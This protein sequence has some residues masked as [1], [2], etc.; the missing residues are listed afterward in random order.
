M[1]QKKT[2][3]AMA[4]ALRA[5]ADIFSY[6]TDQ[7]GA[8][9]RVEL[10]VP[11]VL[12]DKEKLTVTFDECSRLTVT[13]DA[14]MKAGLAVRIPAWARSSYPEAADGYMRFGPLKAGE[15]ASVNLPMELREIREASDEHYYSLAYGPYLLA[16]VSDSKELLSPEITEIKADGASF[17]DGNLTLMPLYRIDREHYHVYYYK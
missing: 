6:G 15:S 10:P 1:R 12:D 9:V 17:S 8:D 2:A 11:S 7:D 4:Q 5:A 16:A 14:D 3:A 13:A